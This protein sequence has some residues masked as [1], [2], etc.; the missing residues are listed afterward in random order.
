MQLLSLPY[1]PQFWLLQFSWRSLSL[2]LSP[3]DERKHERLSRAFF[4]LPLAFFHFSSIACCS[5]T[6]D[7]S[8]QPAVKSIDLSKASWS[9]TR[10]PVLPVVASGFF[11][12]PSS[13]L[14]LIP[15]SSLSSPNIFN[16]VSLASRFF[17]GIKKTRRFKP[18][19]FRVFHYIWLLD[20]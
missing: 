8:S 15:S 14:Q 18:G 13:V 3:A 4:R 1:P 10:T 17:I 2:S 11:A 5:F 12:R 7:C 20:I 19:L 16:K 9:S 6:N